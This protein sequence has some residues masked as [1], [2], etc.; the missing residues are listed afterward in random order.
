[1][2][3]T[4]RLE[5]PDL[6]LADLMTTWPETIGVFMRHKMLCV[7]CMVN[8]YHSVLDACIEYE[9]NIDAFYDELRQAISS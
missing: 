4:S 3:K 7:G 5:D 8:P 9:L 1:M 6:S 2:M